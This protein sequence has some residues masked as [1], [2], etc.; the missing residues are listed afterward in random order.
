MV[1]FRE[2]DNL[3]CFRLDG[4]IIH[5]F[6]P[7]FPSNVQVS[8]KQDQSVRTFFCVDGY[9][10]EEGGG[11]NNLEKYFR[12]IPQSSLLDGTDRAWN[13]RRTF[14]RKRKERKRE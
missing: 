12:Y 14:S 13:A 1:L 6:F 11:E 4:E 10:K 9:N 7:E 5:L 3:K 8:R 2:L